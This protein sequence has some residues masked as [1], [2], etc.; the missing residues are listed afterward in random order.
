M[1]RFIVF[2]DSTAAAVHNGGGVSEAV[3]DADVPTV[4]ADAIHQ[5]RTVV[6]VVPAGSERATVAR[7]TPPGPRA[8]DDRS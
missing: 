4:V 5:Q 3:A 1:S 6:L 8:N 2:D 7:I